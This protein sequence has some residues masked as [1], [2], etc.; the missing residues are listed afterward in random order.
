MGR[1]CSAG[2]GLYSWSVFIPTWFKLLL[3][4]QK[5]GGFP[6]KIFWFIKVM[7]ESG[8]SVE[9]SLLPGIT[10]LHKPTSLLKN[11]NVLL[12]VNEQLRYSG[13]PPLILHHLW[14][15]SQYFHLSFRVMRDK[16][17]VLLAKVITLYFNFEDTE[18]L[19][20]EKCWIF[21]K[22]LFQGLAKLLWVYEQILSQ[23][24]NKA[25]IFNTEGN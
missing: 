25:Y 11:S 14:L 7:F 9:P 2:S 15:P 22:L 3:L 13:S 5:A 20:L 19:T 6:D 10:F 4:L 17:F 8:V 16:K 1:I 24:R 12:S 21:F 18:T 23:F